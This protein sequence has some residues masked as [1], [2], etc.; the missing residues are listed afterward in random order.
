MASLIGILVEQGE[1]RQLLTNPKVRRTQDPCAR[2]RPH[3][4]L[5]LRLRLP[6][7]A[8]AP[9]PPLPFEP[10]AAVA[11]VARA[12]SAATRATPVVADRPAA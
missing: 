6:I 4:L 11:R 2:M 1:T 8:I 9:A 12:A 5:Q 10:R 3:R 7:A